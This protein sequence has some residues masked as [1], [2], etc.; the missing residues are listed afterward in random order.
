MRLPALPL[1]AVLLSGPAFADGGAGLDAAAGA[2]VA[3]EARALCTKD[4]GKLW[5]TSLCGPLLLVERSTRK[6]VANQP[7]AE[8][9]LSPLS[10]V[11]VGTLPPEVG[12]GNTATQW[13]GVRW[14]ML[15]W[16]LSEDKEARARLL[17]HESWHRVQDGLGLP[18]NM[19]G[20]AHLDTADGRWLLQLEWRALSAALKAR[21]AARRE[22]VEDALLFRSR[23]RALFP[24]AAAEERALE[25]NEGLA[26]YTG[27][28]LSAKSPEAAARQGLERAARQQS[29]VRSFAYGS[30]PA[31]G[32]LLDALAK[33]WRKGLTPEVDLGEKLITALGLPKVLMDEEAV[34]EAARAY[35]GPALREAEDT[36]ARARA[37]RDAKARRRL[38]EGAV[39]VLPLKAMQLQFDP[40]RVFPLGE[41]GS[42]YGTLTVLD[43]WGKLQADGGALMAPD[44][45]SVRVPAPAQAAGQELQGEGW[46]LSLQPGWKLAPGTRPGDWVVEPSAP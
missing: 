31:Y 36:L 37:E 22:A 2:R 6:V 38:V 28:V 39:L 11:Y 7:D 23:R 20:N 10:G 17:M 13:A 42:V 33:G 3:K 4:G 46:T 26:E 18:M 27:V 29:F 32:V 41:H 44:F 15:L 40:R 16:P 43:T 21:G 9:R 14:T 1:L 30:G 19:P 8:G 5:G 34:V 25:L 24:Q 45:R 35:D 12:I